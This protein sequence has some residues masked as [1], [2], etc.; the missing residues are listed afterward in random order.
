MPVPDTFP[1]AAR[2]DSVGLDCAYCEHFVGPECWPDDERVSR[3]GLHDLPLEIQLAASGYKDGEWFCRDFTAAPGGRA[4]K[5]AVGHLQRV[6]DNLQPQVLYRFM[7]GG[8]NLGEYAFEK[9]RAKAR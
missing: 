8:G 7:A 6:R 5:V 9:L 1:H 3:C 4:A 2:W